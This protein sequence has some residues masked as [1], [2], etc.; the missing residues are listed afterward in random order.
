MIAAKWRT[1]MDENKV[2]LLLL[3][4]AGY[5]DPDGLEHD[6]GRMLA[7]LTPSYA[8]YYSTTS[9]LRRLSAFR[10]AI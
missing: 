3:G 6:A 4:M 9:L 1:G 5:G 8:G 2:V 10:A 7:S